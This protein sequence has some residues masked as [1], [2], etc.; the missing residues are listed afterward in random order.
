MMVQASITALWADRTL[1]GSSANNRTRPQRDEGCAMDIGSASQFAAG[2]FMETN[3]QQ[4]RDRKIS[5]ALT[6][7]TISSMIS[8][9]SLAWLV[10]AVGEV[11]GFFS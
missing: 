4:E 6:L 2:G 8:A 9:A 7:I 1:S 5:A 3:S 11:A 10:L